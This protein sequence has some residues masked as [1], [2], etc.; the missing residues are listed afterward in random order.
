MT[1]LP[2]NPAQILSSYRK[3]DAIIIVCQNNTKKIIEIAAVNDEASRVFGFSNSELVGKELAHL[4]PER[5]ASTISEFVE[6]EDDQNDLLAV[7][8]KI[9]NFSVKCSDGREAEFKLRIIRGEAIDHN[10]WFHLV[11]IDEE[12]LRKTNAFREVLREN[13][14]G[15]EIIDERTGLANR[16]SLLKD[17]ELIVYHV[18]NSEISASFAIIEINNYDMLRAQRTQETCFKL[19]QHIGQI[20]KLKLRAEDTVGTLSERSLGI[21]LIDAP[22]EPARMV[23]NRLR[24]AI[25]V[26]PMPVSPREELV[27]QVNIG[28]AQ[29]DGKIKET[30]VLEKCEEFVASLRQSSHNSVQLVV[31]HERRI[32][33][34]DRRK[35]D[36][37]IEMERRKKERRRIPKEEK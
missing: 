30:E 35:E 31:T 26:S 13:F 27:A 20:C 4:L 6:Y 9:R 10:P 7:L 34:P 36:L 33:E 3:S 16:L 5:V 2:I 18:R 28:F 24:W 22:Q 8:N 14:K 1:S 15:H 29:I 11:L 32:E 12:K 25:S 21:I 37:P 19:H 23:L 17:I